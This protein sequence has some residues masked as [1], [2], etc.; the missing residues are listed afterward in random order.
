MSKDPLADLLLDADEVDRA[1]LSKAV[2]GLLGIDSSTGR[3]V[4]KPGFAS[5]DTRKKVLAYLLGAKVAVLLAKAESEAVSPIDLARQT[6]LPKGT[7][8]PKLSH[9]FDER[10]VSK[11]A[12]GAYY[13]APHQIHTAVEELR[14][15]HRENEEGPKVSSPTKRGPAR[16]RR[17]AKKSTKKDSG[18]SDTP[19]VGAEG[20]KK[21]QRVRSSRTGPRSALRQLAEGEFFKNPRSIGEIQKHLETRRALRFKLQDLSP[22]LGFLV[23]EGLLDREKNEKKVYEYKLANGE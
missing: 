1:T 21:R 4:L 17:P 20:Q 5:L 22:H 14:E 16:R 8:N 23:R 19:E 11:T 15:G 6:G 10:L 3:V 13:I 7:V 9:L 2:V 12:A 18:Q